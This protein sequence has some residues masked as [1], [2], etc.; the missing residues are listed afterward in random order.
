MVCI[1]V[2]HVQMQS[3]T[4]AVRTCELCAYQVVHVERSQLLV[5]PAAVKN[6][7]DRPYGGGVHVR[8][9]GML[10]VLGESPSFGQGH[11]RCLAVVGCLP[12]AGSKCIVCMPA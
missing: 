9:L 7:T 6:V 12:L 5:W 4:C 3:A 8:N 10:A 1:R 2:V 11:Y